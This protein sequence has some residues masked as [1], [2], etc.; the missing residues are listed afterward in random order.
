VD[1]EH[2]MLGTRGVPQVTDMDSRFHEVQRREEITDVDRSGFDGRFPVFTGRR[3][4]DLPRRRISQHLARTLEQRGHHVR[5][6]V[7]V[8][9]DQI[10][11]G[12]FAVPQLLGDEEARPGILATEVEELP[13]VPIAADVGGGQALIEIRQRPDKVRVDAM[14]AQ[15][16]AK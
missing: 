2:P 16:R 8:D 5:V 10:C 14:V 15:V 9:D 3:I 13:A 7:E 11:L 4:E 1:V 12:S 6:I